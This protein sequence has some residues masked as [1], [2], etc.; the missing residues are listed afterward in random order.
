MAATK[1]AGGYKAAPIKY[2]T[3]TEFDP[4]ALKFGEPIVNK[5]NKSKLMPISYNGRPLVLRVDRRRALVVWNFQEDNNKATIELAFNEGEDP[6]MTMMRAFDTAVVDYVASN[7]VEFLKKQVPP[8]VVQHMYSGSIKEPNDPKYSM[9]FRASVYRRGA[10]LDLDVFDENREPLVLD[11]ITSVKGSEVMMLVTCT[12]LRLTGTNKFSVTWKV[13]NMRVFPRKRLN[14]DGPV[15]M[16]NHPAIE[17]S[18]LSADAVTFTS[19]K[20]TRGGTSIYIYHNKQPIVINTPYMHAPYGISQW[21]ADDD[22]PPKFYLELSFKELDSDPAVRMFHDFIVGLESRVRAESG[23]WT[24]SAGGATMTSIVKQNNPAYPAC[25]K[26]SLPAKDGSVDVQTRMY[27]D[28]VVD[29]NETG[30]KLVTG[31]KVSA[32]ISCSGVWVIGGKFGIS[33]RVLSMS[34]QP[35]TRNAGCLSDDM[36]DDEEVVINAGADHLGLGA[37]GVGASAEAFGDEEEA[38]KEDV[39]DAE[40]AGGGAE[41]AGFGEEDGAAPCVQSVHDEL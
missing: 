1:V 8:E 12:G 39:G 27:D 34:L 18:S 41:A 35:D 31:A 21:R 11:D 6:L 23:A 10:D 17:V 2:I 19:P 36:D 33:F 13:N 28:E 5:L 14:G 4:K 38:G 26:L 40:A 9:T 32:K 15:N 20:M 25:L 29:L 30:L 24:K 7:S 3:P 16:V 22:T 37:G